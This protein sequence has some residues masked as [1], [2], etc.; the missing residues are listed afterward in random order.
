MSNIKNPEKPKKR[1]GSTALQEQGSLLAIYYA[2]KKGANLNNGNGNGKSKEAQAELDKELKRVY[3]KMTKA[4]YDTFINQAK[5]ICKYRLSKHTIGTTT[6]LYKFGWYDG[7]PE[8]I[9]PSDTTTLLP[10]IWNLMGKE[11]WALFG[12]VRQKDSW[13]TADVF[14]IKNGAESKIMKRIKGLKED[15]L[16]EMGDALNGNGAEIFVGTVNTV[17]TEFVNNGTLLPISLK[18]QTSGV[19]V[20]VKETNMHQWKG[21]GV[22]DAMDS[23]FLKDPFMYFNV[24]AREGK[25]SFG[26]GP[27]KQDGGNSLQYFA[28]FKVGDYQTKYLIEYRLS[29]D[30]MK[31]EVKDIKL[32]NKGEERRARAQTGT[33]PVDKLRDM[34]KDYSGKSVDDNVPNK[35]THLNNSSDIKYWS[36]YLSSVMN[37]NKLKKNLGKLNITIGDINEKYGN[38]TKGYITKLFEIDE[39]C[40]KDPKFTSEKFGVPVDDFPKKIRL[41]LRQLAV[42]RAM[43][44]AQSKKEMNEF[45]MK[46]YYLAAKQNISTLDLNGPFLKVS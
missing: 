15:Y 21:S 45:I 2:Y 36:D 30:D 26:G 9:P 5:A 42:L 40:I 1:Q 4:W 23:D 28:K 18:M 8:G 3:P 35:N 41:K 13:N 46:T 32:T 11:V 6:N 34:I 37:D 43:I 14:M 16:D 19:S 44:N 31:G 20:T 33:V 10:D 12:G 38:D 17:L 22:V 25:L 27:N 24:L 39:M 7:D 29:G